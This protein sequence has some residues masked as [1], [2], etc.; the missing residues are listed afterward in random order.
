MK[1]SLI[2]LLCL[3]AF[4]L[5][6]PAFVFGAS[7]NLD[8]SASVGSFFTFVPFPF[9]EESRHDEKAANWASGDVADGTSA[10]NAGY[11][12]TSG[13]GSVNP[14]QGVHFLQEYT[15]DV[16]PTEIFSPVLH[17]DTANLNFNIGQDS[18]GGSTGTLELFTYSGPD[19]TVGGGDFGA[20]TTSFG[21]FGGGAHSEDIGSSIG[22]IDKGM[23]GT[24]GVEFQP[25]GTAQG[26]VS[27]SFPMGQ[28]TTTPILVATEGGDWDAMQ[29]G[30]FGASQ[31]GAQLGRDTLAVSETADSLSYTLDV[32]YN[33][34]NTSGG[35][36]ITIQKDLT[37][38]SAGVWEQFQ[39]EIVGVDAAGGDSV[40][41]NN[42]STETTGSFGADPDFSGSL[43]EFAA[44]S[45]FGPGD[46][47][48]FLFALDITDGGDG[49]V[50]FGLQQTG[51]PLA[52]IPEPT[53]VIMWLLMGIGGIGFTIYR[54][55]QK[56]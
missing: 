5:A 30:V 44:D 35:D 9:G 1:K 10:T 38:D 34:L 23:S 29:T 7:V 26:G 22:P 40:M 54:R 46:F 13:I 48:S 42:A 25:N 47:A 19:G 50:N 4:V 21:T 52:N 6:T 33:T 45:S 24:V 2:C 43:L 27:A 36:E 41:F 51:I 53:S 18:F 55:R 32:T 14:S 56:Q 8:D 37:N 39:V 28:P 49:I 15:I 31:G 11:S 12:F 20:G 16:G 3:F 17:G